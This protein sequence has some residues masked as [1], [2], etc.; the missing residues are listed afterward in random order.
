MTSD[1]QKLREAFDSIRHAVE[2]AKQLDNS[3]CES[4]IKTEHL[5]LILA[6]ALQSQ[7]QA[8]EAGVSFSAHKTAR[9][10]ADAIVTAWE[11]K[12]QSVPIY[13][14]YMVSAGYLAKPLDGPESECVDP[15][16]I[17]KRIT[18]NWDKYPEDK[19]AARIEGCR[20]VIAAMGF[21]PHTPSDRIQ[22]LEAALR[23]VD[24]LEHVTREI[25][26]IRKG[27]ISHLIR[28]R[29]KIRK[30]IQEALGQ[31]EADNV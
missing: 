27:N 28:K 30:T 17:A 10:F 3:Y 12:E 2:Y 5:R 16:A 20:D 21:T 25:A 22:Q 8:P 11:N 6:L 13:A 1:N 31:K 15:I 23:K 24:E 4:P 14:A 18:V 19:K 26:K 9:E 29:D 7:P